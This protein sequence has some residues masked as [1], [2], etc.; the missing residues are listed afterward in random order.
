MKA[1]IFEGVKTITSLGLIIKNYYIDPGS[2][3]LV[4]Q[5]IL[6]SLLGFLFIIRSKLVKVIKW[7]TTR[8]FKKEDINE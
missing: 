7:V 8:I 2:G 1:E 4:I 5:I 6:A 3:S